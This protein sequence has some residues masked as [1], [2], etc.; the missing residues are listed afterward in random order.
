MSFTILRRVIYRL[1][2]NISILSNK[3]IKKMTHISDLFPKSSLWY[4]LYKKTNY[5]HS[6]EGYDG[7]ETVIETS[8]YICILN[9]LEL[10]VKRKKCSNL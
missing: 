1:L 2:T 5:A 6:R 3:I 4:L 7:I 9:W 10:N 8:N